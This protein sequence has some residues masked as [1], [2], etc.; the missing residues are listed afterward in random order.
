MKRPE[1][2]ILSCAVFLIFMGTGSIQPYITPYLRDTLSLSSV[3]SSLILTGVYLTMSLTRVWTGRIV[4]HIGLYLATFIGALTYVIFPGILASVSIFSILQLDA[5][6]W[7]MGA[8]LFWTG[9]HS[10]V[11]N[12]SSPTRY[13]RSTGTILLSTQIGL[14]IGFFTLGYILSKYGYFAFF[15]F[16]ILATSLGA[17]TTLLVSREKHFIFP[18]LQLREVFLS[19]VSKKAWL[20]SLFLFVSSFSY[21]IILNLLNFFVNTN[22]GPAMMNK[23][24]I[25]F[26]L[27]AG[28]LGF[29]GGT[30]SDKIGRGK[31]LSIAFLVGFLGSSIS[32]FYRSIF[33]VSLTSFLLG[34]QFAVIPTVSMAWIGDIT[35]VQRRPTVVA[36]ISTWKD[37]GVAFSIILCGLLNQRKVSFKINL[38]IFAVIFFF[39]FI[40]AALNANKLESAAGHEVY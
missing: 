28:I 3:K 13:G 20:I 37:S 11:L 7:G 8:A 17:I 16:T 30:L 10:Q 2:F 34:I 5:I 9:I 39:L 35:T 21:G 32:V 27:S 22:F 15:R 36:A 6:F 4:Y 1:L 24:L 31:I 29:M 23:T 26:Y 18:K 40:A 19:M 38:A 25:F 33:A 14:L 12:I